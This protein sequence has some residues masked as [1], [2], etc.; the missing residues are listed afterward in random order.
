MLAQA[1]EAYC[2]SL[3]SGEDLTVQDNCNVLSSIIGLAEA[4]MIC[5]SGRISRGGSYVQKSPCRPPKAT[6]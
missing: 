3:N 6:T 5:G 1:E 2:K 4:Y